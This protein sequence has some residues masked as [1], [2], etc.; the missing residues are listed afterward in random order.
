MAQ[1]MQNTGT[2]IATDID[3][4]RL[5][6]VND[7][8]QRLGISI[9]KTVEYDQLPRI[10][11]QI[12]PFDAV[13]LDVP[14]SN[15]AVLARRPE[16]RLRITSRAI[17]SLTKTQSRLLQMGAELIKTG[18][19]I[20]YSTCSILKAENEDMVKQFLFANPDFELQQQQIV[21][22]VAQSRQSLDHDGGYYAIITKKQPPK[23][24]F[25]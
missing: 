7:N 17:K 24:Q 6:K 10:I 2:I 11:S 13:L 21:L 8:C 15:T 23:P 12:P 3:P 19:R 25:S 16:V 5:R 20:C 18:A 1:M 22:P 14:C 4:K 9:V